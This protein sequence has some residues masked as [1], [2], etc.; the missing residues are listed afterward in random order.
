[1]RILFGV[2][3]TGNGHISRSRTLAKALKAVGLQVD[4]V[5]SGRPADGYFDMAEFADYRAFSGLTFVTH[6]GKICPWRTLQKASLR[7]FWHDLKALNCQDYD[8]V[9]SDFEPLT[10]Y[11]AQRAN[12]ASLTIS[13]QASFQWSIPRWGEDSVARQL[14]RHYAPVRQALGLHWYHFGQPLLPPIIDHIA[15]APD[16]GAFLVYLP[17]ES[18]EAIM[19]LLGRFGQHQFICFHPAFSVPSSWRNVRFE[20]P[21]RHAFVQTLAGCQG[22]I[23][24][25]GFELASEALTLGKKMLVKPLGGQF[26]Q[27]T[28][29]KT[30]EL[31]G[32]ATLMLDLDG[33][34]LRHWLKQEGVGKVIYPDV[35]TQLAQWLA[36]GTRQSVDELSEDLWLRTHF[37]EEVID[38]L[39]EFSGPCRLSDGW[40]SQVKMQGQS[41]P[42]L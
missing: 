6:E 42:W 17:F 37:P 4:Y 7:T 8:L 16:H 38:R 9:I 31:M 19:A 11:G 1:M 29:G 32:L 14:M 25:A 28:N 41:A 27:L 30:L 35:A 15:P 39:S 12:V 18:V 13:H 20:P 2:Q 22:V 3:G 33:H 26:E 36:A 40:L 10:A 34:K 24:N 21:A 23:S 5:F